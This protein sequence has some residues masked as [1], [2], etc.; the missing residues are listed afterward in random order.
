MS[1]QVA[2]AAAKDAETA[3]T[4]DGL[5]THEETNRQSWVNEDEK[6]SSTSG[7]N[8]STGSGDGLMADSESETKPNFSQDA[9][10][11]ADP[12]QTASD[13]KRPDHIPK[14]FWD[15]TAGKLNEKALATSYNDLRKQ[16]NKMTQ[17]TGK[18]PEDFE[19]YLEDF[20]PPARSRATGDQKEGDPLNRFGDMDPADPVF[21]ALAKAAKFANLDQGKFTDFTQVLMEEIHGILPEP[22]NAEKEMGLL[23]EGGEAIVKTNKAWIDRLAGRGVLNENQYNLM[24]K[25]GSTAEGVLLTNALRIENGEKP[26]PVNASVATGRKTP[27]E[28]AAMMAD[29]RYLEE[30]PAGDAYRDEVEKEFA[31]THGTD[32]SG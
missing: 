23:G 26:I 3:G 24:L 29:K 6:G 18:A 2:D 30:G 5:N 22:F 27:A 4:Q 10:Q 7:D 20:K 1:E 19:A 32:P 9:S 14:Q 15:E 11:N 25:F 12:S 21:K 28:C 31:L 13:V 16:F 17:D 8:G